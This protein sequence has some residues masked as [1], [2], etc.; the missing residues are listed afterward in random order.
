MRTHTM[1]ARAQRAFADGLSFMV[2]YAYNN[3]KRQEW[4]D[5]RAQF[6]IFQ[7]GEGWEWR[8]TDLPRHRLGL[9]P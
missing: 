9:L 6:K 7:T 4:F 1:E 5:D 2:A 8:P 3:E